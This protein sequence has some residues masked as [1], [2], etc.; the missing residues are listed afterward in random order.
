LRRNLRKSAL[1]CGEEHGLM[2]E[3]MLQSASIL[4]I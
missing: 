3:L 2:T 1:V 4:L